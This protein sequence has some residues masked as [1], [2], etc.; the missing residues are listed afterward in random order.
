[1]NINEINVGDYALYVDDRFKNLQPATPAKILNVGVKVKLETN[2]FGRTSFVLKLPE[3]ILSTHSD[4]CH[5]QTIYEVA[6]ERHSQLNRKVQSA[7]EARDFTVKQILS[8]SRV[9][10]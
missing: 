6:K 8:S 10:E 1:M 4:L 3:Q 5:A 9:G 7:I 2:A